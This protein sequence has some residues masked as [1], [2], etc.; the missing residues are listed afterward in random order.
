VSAGVVELLVSIVAGASAVI[1]AWMSRG[2]K[3]LIGGKPNHGSDTVSGSL[4]QLY[5]FV[6]AGQELTKAN[7][8]A[9]DR[10]ER[11]VTNDRTNDN[12]RFVQLD[13]R[14]QAME[15]A[16]CPTHHAAAQAAAQTEET[17]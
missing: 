3:K 10:L 2:A 5:K 15:Q 13:R 6:E 4:E 16:P 9:I 8:R 17:P 11:A 7:G 14:I 12:R 1:A